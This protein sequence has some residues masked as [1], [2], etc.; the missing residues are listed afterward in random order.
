ML[1]KLFCLFFLLN[2]SF[3]SA[4]EI[5]TWKKD[6]IQAAKKARQNAYCPYS[7]YQVG[8]AIKTKDGHIYLGANVENAA[9]G[10][11][12]CAER[13]AILNCVS[14]GHQ[15]IEAI[16]IVTRDGGSPCGACRQMINEF[17][18]NALVITSNED[19]TKIE[20]YLLS[21]LLKDAFGPKNVGLK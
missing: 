21:D 9:Y 8:S 19:E 3:L 4:K 6:L 2:I 15:D 7:K 5:N 20:E 16:A 12:I 13:S 10:S 14:N 17:N 1:K 11:T 18:P